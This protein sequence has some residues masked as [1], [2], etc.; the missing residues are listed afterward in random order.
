LPPG[1]LAAG[2]SDD[3]AEAALAEILRPILRLD[4]PDPAAAWRAHVEATDE[5]SRHIDSLKLRTLRFTGPGTDLLVGLSPRS[6]WVG[7]FSRTPRGVFFTPNIP[8]EEIFATPDAR[9]TE[10]RVTC[11]R[12]VGILG[13]KVEGAWF[14]FGD[15]LVRSCGASRNEDFLKSYIDMTPGARRLGEVALVDSAGPVARS[16]LVF[17]NGLIDE[18]AACHI[19]LGSG[20]EEAFE[21]A[22]GMDPAARAAEGY[23]DC[24]VHLDFMI[25]SE[26][27]DVTGTDASGR[28]I[29]IIR[30]GSFVF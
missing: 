24:L 8:T 12:P 23:N 28:E 20:F 1:R 2:S 27:T 10:G 22:E 15:G 18:N 19:A 29:P 11:T 16:G 25:G 3:E 4:A 26:E 17:D 6:R 9:L 7:G 13:S 14:V 5:R 21:G 30:R